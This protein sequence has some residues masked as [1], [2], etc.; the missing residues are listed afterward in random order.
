MITLSVDVS[1]AEIRYTTGGSRPTR[2]STRYEKP[3]S[4]PSAS[5]VRTRAFTPNGG[6]SGTSEATFLTAT[7]GVRYIS[8]PDATSSGG[9]T[10][11]LLHNDDLNAVL[12]EALHGF[13]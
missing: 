7:N 5:Q 8:K 6:E 4:L 10:A 3:F 2:T 13:V 11:S 12:F 1:D 9:H